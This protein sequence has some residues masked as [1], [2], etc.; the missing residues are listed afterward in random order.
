MSALVS[1]PALKSILRGVVVWAP[2]WIMS[3][4]VFGAIGVVY[5]YFLKSDTY[6]SSQALLVRD[7]AF[8]YP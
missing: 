5:A 1:N 2:L 7:E 3:T 4:L 8:F 6:L